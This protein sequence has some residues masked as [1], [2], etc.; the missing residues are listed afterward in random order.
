MTEM[1]LVHVPLHQLRVSEQNARKTDPDPEKL[2]EL[3]AS[4]EA[5]GQ[6]V[7]LIISGEELPA[8]VIGGGRRIAEA[9]A[10]YRAA[11]GESPWPP[12]EVFGD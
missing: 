1:K 7:P 5:H 8:T 2:L 10:K 11:R 4:I 3:A 9:S 12:T 6:L